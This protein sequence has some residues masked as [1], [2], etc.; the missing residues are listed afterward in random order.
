MHLEVS[1]SRQ[2]MR[3]SASQFVRTSF[4]L[5]DNSYIQR[6]LDMRSTYY[7]VSLFCLCFG[8][9]KIVLF[10]KRRQTL[11][12]YFVARHVEQMF[13][14]NNVRICACYYPKSHRDQC[15]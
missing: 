13:F 5:E 11:S 1:P 15:L 3:Q 4:L 10:F 9:V 14:G 12:S 2:L 8:F 7:F 6:A